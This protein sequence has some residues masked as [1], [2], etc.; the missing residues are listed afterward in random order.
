MTINTLC[1][2]MVISPILSSSPSSQENPY[3]TLLNWA[4]NITAC[5]WVH[6]AASA[7]IYSRYLSRLLCS[8]RINNPLGLNTDF[9]PGVENII[10]DTISR[11]HP[12]SGSPPDF[13]VLFKEFPQLKS[14]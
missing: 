14:C 6:K 5:S 1:S 4:D 11:L 9:I 10:V 8:L 12:I 7:T 13:S 3:P 2:F